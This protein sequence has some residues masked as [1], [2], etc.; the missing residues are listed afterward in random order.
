MWP[1]EEELRGV[2][3]VWQMGLLIL[4]STQGS[5]LL[6]WLVTETTQGV[7]TEVILL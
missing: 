3:G 6:R 7:D 1:R 5:V 2:E 4:M